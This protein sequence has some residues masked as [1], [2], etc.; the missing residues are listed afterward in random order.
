MLA[1]PFLIPVPG[2][3]AG[4]FGVGDSVCVVL[5]RFGVEG[6]VLSSG[7]GVGRDVIARAA[8]AGGR[9]DRPGGRDVAWAG[10][11][12][13]GADSI[14]IFRAHYRIT[15]LSRGVLSDDLH[16]VIASQ[17]ADIA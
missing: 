10:S 9:R 3:S 5:T 12:F 1:Q 6:R 17:A 14:H 8:D 2:E 4:F 11:A 15:A 13:Q 16:H 7:R